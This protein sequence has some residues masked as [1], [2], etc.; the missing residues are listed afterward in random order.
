MAAE[1]IMIYSRKIDPAGVLACL[2]A[3]SPGMSVTEGPG[4]WSQATVSVK[5]GW[6]KKASAITFSH[7]QDYYAGKD[8]PRQLN[9]MQGYF[10]RFPDTAV[11]SRIMMLIGS[12]QFGLSMFPSPEPELYLD[13][14]DERLKFVFAVVKHLDGAIFVPSGLRDAAGRVLYDA[15]GR[16][17][18]AAVMPGIYV[19]APQPSEM[20]LYKGGMK[21][22]PRSPEVGRIARRALCLAA[23]WFRAALERE[24]G[25]P[26]SLEDSR[27]EFLEWVV[28]VGIGG[29]LEPVEK[30][31]LEQPIGTGDAQE[32]MRA[33]WA[34]EAA[35][36]LAWVVG[37]YELPR[38]DEQ[39]N[40]GVLG[41]ALGLSTVER[42]KEFLAG[43]RMR[44]A[45]E[46]ETLSRQLLGIHWRLREQRLRPGRKEFE[47]E[48][49]DS[50]FGKLPLD[51]VTFVDGDLAIG[52]V[53]ISAAQRDAYTVC[54]LA[55]QQ[56][57][58][59]IN[60]VCGDSVVYSKTDTQT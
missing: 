18:P 39:V 32:L 8:F 40:V 57:H 21:P 37:A 50:W 59:A 17:D 55:V 28:G 45:A 60:W 12:F 22:N 38:Y 26:E 46:I 35:G 49:Q 13:S 5:G 1:P 43:A 20:P 6:F 34:V 33:E 27:Q 44:S 47:K 42:G 4:G 41:K 56:R 24:D 51:G 16:T 15:G 29:E 53:G 3:M 2:K 25:T 48:S 7:R 14:S 10:S 54:T 58:K 52:G 11:K 9:G 23:V 30:N 19:D 31:L 36:V